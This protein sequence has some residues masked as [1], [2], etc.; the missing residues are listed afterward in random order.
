[1]G[2]IYSLMVKNNNLPLD[3]NVVMHEIP[4]L[5]YHVPLLNYYAHNAN[6][7]HIQFPI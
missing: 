2:F 5:L 4:L 6:N 3:E 1:M 7:P